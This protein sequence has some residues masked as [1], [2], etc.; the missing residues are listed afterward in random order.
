MSYEN[1]AWRQQ[2][3]CKGMDTDLFFPEKGRH[4]PER[5]DL[6]AKICGGCPVR[7]EC[8]HYAIDNHEQMGI[9]GGMAE[10]RRRAYAQ[11][12]EYRKY[13]DGK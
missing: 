6:V 1:G 7:K 2:A 12:E 9:W 11:G 5:V 13:R 3:N 10:K 8:L 4:T